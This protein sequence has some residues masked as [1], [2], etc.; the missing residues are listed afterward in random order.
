MFKKEKSF[1][2]SEELVLIQ[3]FIKKLI[4]TFYNML[5]KL[6]GQLLEESTKFL[7]QLKVSHLRKY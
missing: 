6:A 4:L 5:Y 7:A 2:L 1:V 3:L